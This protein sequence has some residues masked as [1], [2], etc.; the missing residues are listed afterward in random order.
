[1]KQSTAIGDTAVGTIEEEEV[2]TA[3]LNITTGGEVCNC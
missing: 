3:D 2:R 1:V